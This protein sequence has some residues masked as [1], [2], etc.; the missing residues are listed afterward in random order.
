MNYST[1]NTVDI[2]QIRSFPWDIPKR[3]DLL[4][5]PFMPKGGLY[6]SFASTIVGVVAQQVTRLLVDRFA[7][8][9]Y[10]QVIDREN[11]WTCQTIPL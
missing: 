3:S 4:V 10:P 2:H 1:Y 6:W 9:K 7:I 11:A 8:S 5:L